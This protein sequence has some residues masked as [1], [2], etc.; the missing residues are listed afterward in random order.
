MTIRA[1]VW[2]LVAATAAVT[3]G[4]TLW[5]RIYAMRS[6][7]TRQAQSSADEIADDIKQGL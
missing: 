3:A 5:V 4:A 1:K 2:I 7:L 6:E